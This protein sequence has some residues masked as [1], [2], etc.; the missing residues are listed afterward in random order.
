MDGEI[1]LKFEMAPTVRGCHLYAGGGGGGVG[2]PR[3]KPTIVSGGV[4]K[5]R[6]NWIT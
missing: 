6:P 1:A 2:C 5:F 3:I 4:F